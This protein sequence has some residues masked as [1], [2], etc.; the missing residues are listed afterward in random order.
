MNKENNMEAPKEIYIDGKNTY[1]SLPVFSNYCNIKYIR[2]DLTE[3]TWEDMLEIVKIDMTLFDGFSRQ[4][5]VENHF[6]EV[7][8]RFKEY[9]QKGE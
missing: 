3:L 1:A 9:K 8:R 2:A 4:K 6:E 5:D 7:L